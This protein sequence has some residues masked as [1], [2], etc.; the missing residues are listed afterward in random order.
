VVGVVVGPRGGRGHVT[1]S[2]SRVGVMMMVF[3]MAGRGS[4]SSRG[5]CRGLLLGCAAASP[6]G[7]GP[8]GADQ[9]LLLQAY[10]ARAY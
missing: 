7:T 3:M 5:W 10:K 1:S 4:S 9:L 8:W 2:S 6:V